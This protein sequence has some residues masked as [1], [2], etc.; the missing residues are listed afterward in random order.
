MNYINSNFRIKKY[1]Q[2]YSVEV[3]VPKWTLFGIRWK[4]THYISYSGMKDVPYY[5]TTKGYAKNELLKLVSFDTI[6]NS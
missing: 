6:E 2:G 5:F 3:K 1:N 4:W